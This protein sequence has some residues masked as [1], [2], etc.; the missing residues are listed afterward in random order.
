[1]YTPPDVS[2]IALQPERPRIRPA[3]AR[4]QPYIPATGLSSGKKRT[5]RLASNENP[6]GASLK[7]MQAVAASSVD[8]ERYPDPEW[9]TLRAAIANTFELPVE[10]LLV[11]AGSEQLIHL[12]CRIMLEPGDNIVQSRHG[13][14]VYEN[15]ATACGAMTHYA[16]GNDYQ[17][18]IDNLLA[19]VNDKT[20]ILFLDNP[21]NPSGSWLKKN[22][23]V[24]LRAELPSHVLLVIDSA[25]AEYVTDE[26]YSAGHDLVKESIEN[27]LDNVVVL[28]SFSK[29]YGLAGLRIGWGFMPPQITDA[30]NR[31]R[32]IFNVA[33]AAQNAAVASLEDLDFL[34]HSRSYN[35]LWREIVRKSLLELGLIVPES[36]ANFL[37]VR[38][39]QGREQ[40]KAVYRGLFEQGIITYSLDAYDMADSLRVTIG[41]AEENGIFLDTIAKLLKQ[42]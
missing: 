13:F 7:A 9:D 29:L 25:Y 37:L 28:H 30:I 36:M 41:T 10:H 38:F 33:V 4:I 15:A 42:S 12:I 8:M 34:R 14:F 16:A 3:I 21:N 19:A 39:P 22:E 31:L 2:D 17:H 32:T 5:I 35:E 27:N 6:L 26:E 23:L 40:A 1:M 24:R 11:G 20:R 18:S